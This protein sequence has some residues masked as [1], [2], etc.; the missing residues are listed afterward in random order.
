MSLQQATRRDDVATLQEILHAQ[1]MDRTSALMTAAYF[2][3]TD[4]LKVLIECAVDVNRADNTGTTAL[5]SAAQTGK[6]CEF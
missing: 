5:I 3:H 2:N 6:H 4:C 1:A